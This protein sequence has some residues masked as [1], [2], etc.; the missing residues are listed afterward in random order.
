LFVSINQRRSASS[1]VFVRR[2]PLPTRQ[3]W[4]GKTQ[5]AAPPRQTAPSSTCA[6][7][8]SSQPN[9]TIC[10][11]TV[12]ERA[13]RTAFLALPLH[14]ARQHATHRVHVV[15]QHVERAIRV[16]DL[17]GNR[18]RHI[19]DARHFVGKLFRLLVILA[20]KQIVV[21]RFVC[22]RASRATFIFTSRVIPE[23]RK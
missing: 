11:R 1:L 3:L 23:N 19:S 6:E 17:N 9:A 21:C 7:T 14:R 8:R 22:K 5:L 10:R 12:S 16:V 15:V 13:H 2:R 4:S 20:S 18:F